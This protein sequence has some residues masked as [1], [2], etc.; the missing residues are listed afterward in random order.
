M[1]DSTDPLLQW[2]SSA[3]SLGILAAAVLAFVRGWVVSGAAHQ[4]VLSERDRA[5]AMVYKQAEIAER[6]LEAAEQ[7][8]RRSRD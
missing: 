1:Q 2:L 6:A 3:G 5:L 8:R 7:E 4:R